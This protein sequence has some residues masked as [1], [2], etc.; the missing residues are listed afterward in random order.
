MRKKEKIKDKVSEEIDDKIYEIPDLPKFELG[1]GLVNILGT[2]AE[3][4]LKENF[5][6]PKKLEDEA[7]YK[8]RIWF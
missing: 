6:N 2:E 3:D 7:K 8:R 1:D 5:V 4:V